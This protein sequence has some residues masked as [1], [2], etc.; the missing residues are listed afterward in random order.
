MAVA[1]KK[2]TKQLK[3]IESAYELFTQRGVNMTAV[4]DVVKRA[5][6]AKGTFYL[7]FKDK[8]DLLDQIVLHR[9]EKVVLEAVNELIKLEK[10]EQYTPLQLFHLFV[11]RIIEYLENNKDLLALIEKNLSVCLELILNTDNPVLAGYIE[12]LYAMFE[13]SGYGR[14]KAKQY[15]YLFTNMISSACCDAILTGRPYPIQDI[16]ESIHDIIDKILKTNNK[17]VLPNA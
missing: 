12:R 7:Y 15:I 11:D 2:L 9:S 17:E 13:Q 3:L 4:D 1:D 10:T 5:G 6:V 8:Y 14:D 16:R